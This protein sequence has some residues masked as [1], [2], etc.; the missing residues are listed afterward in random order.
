MAAAPL[1]NC[2]REVNVTWI[3]MSTCSSPVLRVTGWEPGHSKPSFR[4]G[5][6]NW[7]QKLKYKLLGDYKSLCGCTYPQF[8]QS[9]KL[10]ERSHI[11]GPG[12]AYRH[13]CPCCWWGQTSHRNASPNSLQ[14]D[15]KNMFALIKMS[16]NSISINEPMKLISIW[17]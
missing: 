4:S 8:H 17:Q 10:N 3:W 15:V 13:P 16:I 1:L 7:T 12:D 9:A 6:Y 2:E 11:T 5:V 14:G